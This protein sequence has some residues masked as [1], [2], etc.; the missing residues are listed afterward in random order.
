MLWEPEIITIL[1]VVIVCCI[2]A[3]TGFVIMMAVLA[4]AL[5]VL[6]K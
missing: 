2:G 4:I 3:M 5:A 6:R 1:K